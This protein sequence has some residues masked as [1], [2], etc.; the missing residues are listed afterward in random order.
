[1]TQAEVLSHSD[2]LLLPSLTPLEIVAGMW[3]WAVGFLGPLVSQK[4]G[5]LWPRHVLQVLLDIGCK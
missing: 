5:V 2:F 3:G 1:M 4:E